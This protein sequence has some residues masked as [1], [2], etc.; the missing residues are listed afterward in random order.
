MPE[1]S[2]RERPPPRACPGGSEG[3]SA[4]RPP[5]PSPPPLIPNFLAD[6]G[7]LWEDAGPL[8]AQPG[9]EVVG[10]AGVL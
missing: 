4:G 10:G 8:G 2:E 5:G 3:G 7:A 9:M 6:P 1:T